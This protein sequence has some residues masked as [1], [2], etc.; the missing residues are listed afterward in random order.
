M[1]D[2]VDPQVR[3]QNIALETQELLQQRSMAWTETT[4]RAAMLMTLVGAGLVALALLGDAVAFDRTFLIVALVVL[5][6]VLM[7][8]L[9]TF[10]RIGALDSLDWRWIQGL[11]RLRHAR[12]E[13]DPQF[14]RYL[15]TSPYDDINAVLDTFATKTAN[16]ILHGFSLLATLI[17]FLNAMIA[18]F[19]AADIAFLAGYEVE[20]AAIVGVVAFVAV[21]VAVLAS[22][23]RA[24][25]TETRLWEARFPTPAGQTDPEYVDRP[26]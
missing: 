9:S 20:V 21:V 4:N 8:G 5:L 16:P 22:F 7:T 3:F 15:V 12:L 26:A 24:F 2:S 6:F 13:L 14:N 18:A 10:I 1:A 11:N 25:T 19:L 23:Y 17:G